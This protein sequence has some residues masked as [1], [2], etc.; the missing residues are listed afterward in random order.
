MPSSL[1]VVRGAA[2]VT[3]DVGRPAIPPQQV[4]QSAA[5]RAVL[6]LG[7]R[8]PPLGRAAAAAVVLGAAEV[9][10]ADAARPDR[11][12]R[13]VEQVPLVLRPPAQKVDGLLSNG[14]P[15]GGFQT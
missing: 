8:A 10:A 1:S 4:E 9:V 13:L 14:V 11:R 7:A 15:L 12:W 6:L 3:T 2:P 5:E